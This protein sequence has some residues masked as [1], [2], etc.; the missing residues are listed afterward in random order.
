MALKQS[1]RRVDV[2]G[3]E[4]AVGLGEIRDPLGGALG[5]CDVVGM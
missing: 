4:H 3:E 5:G 2:G 1:R